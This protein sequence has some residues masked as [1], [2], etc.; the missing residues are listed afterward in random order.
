M[1]RTIVAA[2]LL[3][4]GVTSVLAPAAL[5][6]KRSGGAAMQTVSEHIDVVSQDGK[7]LVKMH[8]DNRSAQPVHV[9][10]V[11]AEDG[12][13]FGKHFELELAG[14]GEEV[15]YVGPMVKR[16]PFG[17]AD[18]LPVKPHSKH[19]STI[20]ITQAYAFLPGQHT[21]RLRYAGNYVADIKQVS[22]VTPVKSTPVTFTHTGK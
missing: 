20:D 7:V 8:F 16:G 6:A 15:P 4:A 14:S 10:K 21:Y 17:P 11:V 13:L 3:A 1:K 12:E 5:A 2:L 22:S 9:P 19:T 18:Y